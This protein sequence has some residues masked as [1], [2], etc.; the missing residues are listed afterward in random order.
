M[1]QI[2]NENIIDKIDMNFLRFA[3]C[4]LFGICNLSLAE[5]V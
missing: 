3:T 5:E 2:L 1:I 4:L